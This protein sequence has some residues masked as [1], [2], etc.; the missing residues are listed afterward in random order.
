MTGRVWLATGIAALVFTIR[1]TSQSGLFGPSPF[2]DKRIEY[3]PGAYFPPGFPLHGTVKLL[4][5][6]TVEAGSRNRHRVELTIGDMPVEAGT[7]IEVW[8]HFTSDMEEFQATNADAPAHIAAA[9][10]DGVSAEWTIHTNWTQRN[11]PS[12]FPYR[13]CAALRVTGG[14]LRTGDR[15]T[16]DLGGRAGVRMQQYE[17]N[18]FNFRF[19]I[20][21]SGGTVLGYLGDAMMKVTGGPLRQLRV[22]APSVVQAGEE[23][24]VEVV[25]MD[26]WVSQARNSRGLALRLRGGG[27]QGGTF[28]W[29]EAL[30]HYVARDVKAAAEGTLRLQV[31]TADGQYRA[32]SNPVWVEKAPLRRIYFGEL[33]QHSYLHDGRGR[34]EEAYLY[35]RRVGLLDFG[36]VTPHHNF[37]TGQGPSFYLPEKYPNDDWP[38]LQKTTRLVNGWE[39]FVSLLG[40]EYSVATNAGGH[41]NIFYNADRAASTME[42]DPANPNAPIGRMLKT[43]ELARVPTLVIPHIGGGPPDWSHPTDPRIERLF[44]IASVHGVFEESWQKHLEAGLRLGAIAA[45][46]THTASMGIAYPG[47]IYVNSNGLAGVWAWNKTRQSIW[48]G[49]YEKRTFATTGNQRILA[50]F[51]VNGEPM[52]G[53]IASAG[54]REAR[55]EAR[56]SG[57]SPILAVELVKNGRVIHAVRP[58]RAQSQLARIVWGD[59]LYQRRAATGFRAGSLQAHGRLRLR[60]TVNLDQAFEEIMQTRDGLLWKTAAV[61]GDRDGVLVDLAEVTGESLLFRLDDAD[62][63]GVVE[64]AI[65]LKQ[66][67]EQGR[68]TYRHAA[69]Q[70][71]HPYM[72]QMG[73]EPAFTVE[74]ELVDPASP[75]DA[76]F[77]FVD[78]EPLKPGDYFYLRLEQLDTNRAWTS[79]VWVN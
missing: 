30:G 32:V 43:L 40:Y 1:L 42:L 73:L 15:V 39:G 22:Q 35:G 68:F 48:D 72:R 52:G 21:A 26:A 46:D 45:G 74:C 59:N 62:M 3:R 79:P 61:S 11:D 34:F 77:E 37:I 55:I 36:A 18:L 2:G 17:E 47:L 63:V 53:E 70:V 9:L 5:A 51:R 29:E 57:T 8:K 69:P 64:I 60:Q 56:V 4:S 28:R 76:R 78:R 50:D 66:L 31:E 12:V 65:P 16:F 71:N 49:L 44:E 33:H 24:P 13:K 23:F 7:S 14:R 27:V 25:P 67:R 75:A 6:Q 41:H 19:V 58:A 20:A 10:P 38:E 54:A